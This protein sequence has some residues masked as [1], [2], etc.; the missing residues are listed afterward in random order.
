MR[1]GDPRGGDAARSAAGFASAFDDE[2][3]YGRDP[4]D[5]HGWT[6]TFS[7]VA[8][9]RHGGM[10]GV[11]DSAF[12]RR[13][14]AYIARHKAPA[15]VKAAVRFHEAILAWDFP[16]AA[17][18]ANPLVGAAI[19]GDMWLDPDLLRD[20]TVMAFLALGDRARARAAYNALERFSGRPAN[21]LRNEL[22]L[23]YVLDTGRP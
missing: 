16:G 13:V 4:G 22:L 2:L 6:H 15:P 12:F 3:A 18:A 20:G 5:W 23:S 9:L 21:D 1:A 11:V 14:D 7:E 19:K 10:A 17:A 8:A